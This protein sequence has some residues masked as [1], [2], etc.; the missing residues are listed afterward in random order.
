MK[1]NKLCMA[2]IAVSLFVVKY[3]RLEGKNYFSLKKIEHLPNS[4]ILISV[5]KLFMLTYQQ[6]SKNIYSKVSASWTGPL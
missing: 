4:F 2:P 1:P 5:D 6:Y 3:K